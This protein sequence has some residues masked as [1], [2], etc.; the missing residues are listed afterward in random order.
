MK[1][2]LQL[3]NVLFGRYQTL[4]FGIVV[5]TSPGEFDEEQVRYIQ[6]LA[7]TKM[8]LEPASYLKFKTSHEAFMLFYTTNSIS[9]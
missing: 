5:H 7:L 4:P 1:H 6:L 3:L 2:L 9:T 8:V